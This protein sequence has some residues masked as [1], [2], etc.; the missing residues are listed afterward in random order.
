MVRSIAKTGKSYQLV[1]SVPFK[2]AEKFI[3]NVSRKIQ[4]NTYAYLPIFLL[5]SQPEAEEHCNF[6]TDFYQ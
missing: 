6:G 5:H 4:R 1:D 3:I 2:A